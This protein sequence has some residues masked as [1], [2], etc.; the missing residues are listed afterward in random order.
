MNI[1]SALLL[2]VIRI[3][4]NRK[5]YISRRGLFELW[6]RQSTIARTATPT[7]KRGPQ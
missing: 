3:D 6:L 1:K 2:P 5:P 4:G 7:G